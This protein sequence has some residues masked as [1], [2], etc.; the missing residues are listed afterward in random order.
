MFVGGIVQIIHSAVN[1]PINAMGIALGLLRFFG[2]GVVGT[3]C[4]WAMI[5][6]GLL[7]IKS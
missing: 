1:N 7:F 5:I 4:A 6:P 2:A 3:L